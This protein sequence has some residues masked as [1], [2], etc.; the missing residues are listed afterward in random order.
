[1]V[2]N[3]QGQAET[4]SAAIRVGAAGLGHMGHALAVKPLRDSY[5]VLAHDRDAKRPKALRGTR[6]RA[7]LAS[8]VVML[9]HLPGDEALGAETIGL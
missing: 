7:A 1:M 9:T 4:E 6:A 5:Q 8:C 2:D 3:A